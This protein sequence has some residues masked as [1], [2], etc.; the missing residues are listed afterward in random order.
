M[1]GVSGAG[2]STLGRNLAAR[3]AVPYTELDA[4]HHQR[5]WAPLPKISSA[6]R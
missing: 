1:V 5:D 6:A 3:L 2:K 4:I